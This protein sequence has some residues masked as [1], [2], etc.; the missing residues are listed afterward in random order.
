MIIYDALEN[1]LVTGDEFHTYKHTWI[2]LQELIFMIN[3]IVSSSSFVKMFCRL[4]IYLLI[5]FTYLYLFVY[6]DVC[7]ISLHSHY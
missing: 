6:L 5:L 7:A 2:Y 3:Y 4:F 1:D